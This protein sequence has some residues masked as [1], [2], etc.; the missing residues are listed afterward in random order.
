MKKITIIFLT[1]LCVEGFSQSAPKYSN[2]FLSI[3]IGARALGMSNAF[4]TTANDVTAGYWNPAGLTQIT[5][6]F[7]VSLMHAEYFAG[8]AKYDYG[9]FAANIDSA[10]AFGVSII[11]FGV[12]DIPNTTQLIDADGNVDYDRISSFSVADY[13]FI[14]SYARK[15]KIPGLSYG[16]NVKIIYRNVGEFANAWGFGVDAGA[17]YDY[18]TWKFGLMVRDVTSTFNAW[19][20]SLS[21][22]TIDVFNATGN[23][24]PDNSLE[25]TLP[26][27][28][29][30]I[31]KEVRISNKFNLLGEIDFDFSTDGKRNVLITGDPVSV[32]PHMGVEVGYNK[33]IFL[34][35]GVG[36][37]QKVTDILNNDKIT[38]QPNF[39]IGIKFKGIALD[40]AFSD[41]GDQSDA[42]YSNIFSLRFD[43]NKQNNNGTP[44]I[45]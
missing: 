1:L 9:G 38:Y 4:V 5:K 28:I 26:K 13:A 37:F 29:L 36:N 31:G 18:N 41:I 27:A 16:A 34:R 8:I 24:I 20:F 42:L 21:Q 30:G 39:G 11:R 15:A 19:S 43:I 10:S 33:M 32:D 2:E 6:D 14:F 25:L 45:Q 22:E 40:Y 17:Q 23:E 7:Q 44:S 12:D 3:G 35:A